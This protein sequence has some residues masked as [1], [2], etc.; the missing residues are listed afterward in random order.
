MRFNFEGAERYL[1]EQQPPLHL[2]FTVRSLSELEQ[3]LDDI[4]TSIV[5]SPRTPDDEAFIARI[6]VSN[7]EPYDIGPAEITDLLHATKQETQALIDRA[8]TIRRP[9][10]IAVE[11]RTYDERDE[12]GDE[13]AHASANEPFAHITLHVPENR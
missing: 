4:F 7:N 12:Y 6:T 9:Q 11:L 10:E 3:S 2:G 13:T 8:A 5:K 1:A